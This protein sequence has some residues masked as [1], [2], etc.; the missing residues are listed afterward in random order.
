MGSNLR[1]DMAKCFWDP[2]IGH[3]GHQIGPNIARWY[4]F[5]HTKNL[6]FVPPPIIRLFNLR[7]D[8][9]LERLFL[10]IL[11]ILNIL[12]YFLEIVHYPIELQ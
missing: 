2:K 1:E 11:S 12:K 5:C 4:D 10:S 7:F 9:D 6:K 3:T 8:A